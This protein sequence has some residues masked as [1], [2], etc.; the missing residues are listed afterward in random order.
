LLLYFLE[1]STVKMVDGGA[2]RQDAQSFPSPDSA[3]NTPHGRSGVAVKCGEPS[4]S[5]AS[6]FPIVGV[7][8]SAGGLDA[9]SRLLAA[10]PVDLGMAYVLVQHLAA[11]HPSALVEI[12]SRATKMPVLEVE[13]EPAVEPNHVYVIPPARSL[14]I[15]RG[16]LQLEPRPSSGQHRPID[17]FFSA[18]AKDQVDQAVGVVLSGTATDGTLGLE[19]IKAAG[20]ITFAQDG[21]AQQEGMPHSAIDSGC[22]DFVLPPEEIAREIARIGRHPFAALDNGAAVSQDDAHFNRVVAS[23]GRATGVDF[24]NYKANTL[25]RRIA[26]RMALLKIEGFADYTRLLE[27]S[28]AEAQALYQD[29][30][31]NVTSFFRDPEAFE[32]LKTQVFPQLADTLGNDK[33]LRVWTL[34]CSTGQEA[35]S[36][37]VAYAEFAEATGRRNSLQLFATDVN[38][39]GIEKARA[40]IYSKEHIAELSPERLRRF[41][42]EVEGCYR[43]NKSIRDACIFSKHNVLTDPPFSQIDLI[44]CRNLL[45]YLEPVLQ[46]RILPT[47]HYALRPAGFLWLGSSE[48]I[49]RHRNLFEAEDSKRKIYA[50][51]L[52]STTPHFPIQPT[53]TR[54]SDLT[55][56]R[57][58]APA[59]AGADLHKEADRI[60]L[61]KFAPPGVL[62]S[63]DLEI[64]QFR[65]DT[66]AYLAPAP[67]KASLNLLKM[68]REGLLVTVRAAIL[69]AGQQKVP[70]R[71]EGIRATFDG[72]QR[73][74]AIEVIPIHT[75]G[76]GGNAGGFLILFE[77][78]NQPEGL[79]SSVPLAGSRNNVEVAAAAP[80]DLQAANQEHARLVQELSATREFLQSVIEQQE[81]ANEELQ[82]ANEEVQSSNEELQS[83]NEELE[84]TKEEIQ[85]SNQELVTV[86]DELNNRN[87]ELFQANNDLLNLLGSVPLAIVMLGPDLRVRRFNS[88]AESLLSLKSTDVGR[89][90]GDIKFNFDL[91]Q[92]ESLLTE[93]FDTVRAHEVDVRDKHG[94]WYSLRLWP[95][96][97]LENKI[98]GVVILLVDVDAIKQALAFTTSIVATVREPLLVLDA[99]L[100]VR[101]ASRSFYE[102]FHVAAESTER[103]LLFELGN[104]QWDLPDLRRLLEEVLPHHNE[105]NDYVIER[106][107]EHLGPKKML[108]NARTLVQSENAPPLILLAIEDVMERDAAVSAL[109]DSEQRFRALFE[110]GPIAVYSCDLSGTVQEFNRRA[111]ELWGRE[112]KPADVSEKYCGS[113]KMHFPDGT[114]LPHERCPMAD[115]LRGASPAAHDTEVQIERPDGSRISVIV[116]IVPLKNVRGEITGAINCF[117][118]VTERKRA[119]ELLR[120]SRQR[121]ASLIE[122]SNDA[123]ITKSLDGIIQSWN[124]AAE[125][126]YGYKAEEVVGRSIALVMP[127]DHP[128]EMNNILERIRAGEHVDHFETT[129]VR[130][131]GRRIQVSVTVSP[132]KDAAGRV[133]GASKIARDITDQKRLEAELRDADRRKD[134]FLATL[135]HELRGPL[136]PLSNMLEIMKRT[137]GNDELTLQARHTMARQLSQ[138]TRLID[139]L[140]DVSRISR[141]KLLLRRNVVEL[142]SVMY[143]AVE[144]CRPAAERAQQELTVTSPPEPIYVDADPVRLAQVFGNLLNNAC[145]YTESQGRFVL[146]AERQGRDLMVS[147]KDTG[148]GIR[149]EMLPF[150]FNMFTQVDQSLERSQSGLGIGLTLVQRFV[151]LHGGTVQA[152]SEGPGRGSEFIV[153]LPIV[154]DKPEVQ[155]RPEP[156]ESEK[157]TAGRRIL[158]VDDNRDSAT[159]LA[160][161]L[162][163]TGNEVETAHDGLEAVHAAATV[164]PE[165]VLL[166]IG[167]PKMNGYE[168]C[169]KIREQAQGRGI[170]MIALTGWGQ[171]EDRRKSREAGF[172]GHL[173]KPVV[174]AELMKL[175]AELKPAQV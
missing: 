80:T 111:V 85:S 130:R 168:A 15:S 139:D 18:L 137:G 59:G 29:I 9:F 140:L 116:N 68:L 87:Q 144:A 52:C 74:V 118:D 7:G 78:G 120:E 151:E 57:L 127:P 17:Q 172:D 121:L 33:P 22:V 132:I 82:S 115:V 145:K 79:P 91:P 170:V 141:G 24:V 94:H 174:H 32:V 67:G 104:S 8:A 163:M 114:F 72:L 97:T 102:T 50:K 128:D 167:L 75:I 58:A 21:T 30:L 125:R 162:K 84:T 31:I 171:D 2:D 123:I 19:A 64:L 73:E 77:E 90:L 101:T 4:K 156:A 36:V 61:A 96:R 53:G 49:G 13:D 27:K 112:P 54:P 20:G 103:R 154:V 40:G 173:V 152:L 110:S 41:F 63:A 6:T 175:L 161:L 165:V 26:R 23:L 69:R 1:W 169:R 126:L 133:V 135:A 158:V 71:A 10:L 83:I 51:K 108:L 157:T 70:V 3:S 92:F 76:Q 14:V 25:R 146:R 138:M 153:R 149:A 119:E 89:S 43:I 150:V 166:D 5:P 109:R 159:T 47:L 12:L 88:T 60:L 98:D 11:G 35:Y 95:Y 105:V 117:Y 38:A 65:G 134:E 155:P 44:S 48:T 106:D 131:D 99:D 122:S 28:A 160:L 55:S 107:F 100:R 164:R 37:A 34:G 56:A 39:T 142:S 143:Q 81:S 16:R 113:F 129:R 147:I 93:V 46:E 124:A 148:I 66:A 86:N 62:V 136:A 45:I 42:V